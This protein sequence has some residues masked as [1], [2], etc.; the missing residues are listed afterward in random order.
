MHNNVAGTAF[1]ACERC[2]LGVQAHVRKRATGRGGACE[3]AVARCPQCGGWRSSAGHAASIC[4][5]CHSANAAEK[6]RQRLTGCQDCGGRV[7]WSAL[8]CFPCVMRRRNERIA[9]LRRQIEERAVI[10]AEERRI[11]REQR[12]RQKELDRLI[13]EQER[14]DRTWRIPHHPARLVSLNA[15]I[16]GTESLTYGDLVPHY[17]RAIGICDRCET[18]SEE[19][20]D[21]WCSECWRVGEHNLKEE[22]QRAI[23]GD[24]KTLTYRRKRPLTDPYELAEEPTYWQDR[25]PLER[26]PVGTV[27]QVRGRLNSKKRPQRAAAP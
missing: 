26:I 21:G 5:A 12:V 13:R 4:A 17:E 23:P 16:R 8:T 7:S 24:G 19:L 18:T 2:G 27:A 9:E 3:K 10:R 15:I 14:D 25:A 11:A 20:K 1:D 6:A 22:F